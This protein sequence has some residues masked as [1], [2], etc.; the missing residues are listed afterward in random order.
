MLRGAAIRHKQQFE[1]FLERAGNDS[2]L[3]RQPLARTAGTTAVEKVLGKRAEAI[4]GAE[5]GDTDTITAIVSDAS[6]VLGDQYASV[7]SNIAT[8]GRTESLD[9][10][11][12]CLLSDVLIDTSAIYGKTILDTAKDVEIGGATFQVRATDRTG[13]PPIGPYIFWAALRKVA[14]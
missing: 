8:L 10:I 12:R 5:Y 1:L 7:P 4:V 6:M 11:L 9:I 14:D 2:V 13:L 3:V